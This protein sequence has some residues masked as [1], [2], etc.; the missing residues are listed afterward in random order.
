MDNTELGTNLGE[1]FKDQIKT[2]KMG[3]KVETKKEEIKELTKQVKSMDMTDTYEV[4][5]AKLKAILEFMYTGNDLGRHYSY[6]DQRTTTQG[7]IEYA[8][9]LIMSKEESLRKFKSRFDAEY[10]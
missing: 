4:S 5:R 8:Y 2:T 9:N 3:S 6:L 1:L 10:E 7:N